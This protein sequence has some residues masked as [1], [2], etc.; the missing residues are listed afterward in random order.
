MKTSNYIISGKESE[1]VSIAGRAPDNYK[2]R[3]YKKLAPKYWFF[4]K[5]KKDNDENFYTA[6]YY[7]EILD[8]FNPEKVYAE[9]GENAILLCWE[10]PGQFCHRHLV[11][12]WLRDNLNIS[13]EEL[14]MPHALGLKCPKSNCNSNRITAY[15]SMFEKNRIS[16]Q[17]NKCNHVWNQDATH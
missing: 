9:L 12:D 10:P 7:R 4:K 1:A 2:G 16:C 6:Q 15:D 13:I 17:C 14:E 11:A 8:T 5:Y 3:E